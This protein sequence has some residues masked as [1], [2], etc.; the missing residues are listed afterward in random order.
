MSELKKYSSDIALKLN[1]FV[2]DLTGKDASADNL[3]PLTI[4]AIDS[5]LNNDVD[6][7][8][9]RIMFLFNQLGADKDDAVTINFLAACIQVS[10]ERNTEK[11]TPKDT[12]IKVLSDLDNQQLQ[13][14]QRIHESL[15]K[16]DCKLSK[17]EWT[18]LKKNKQ[19]QE[20]VAALSKTNQFTAQ[21]WGKIKDNEQLQKAVVERSTKD[22]YQK[23]QKDLQEFRKY[24]EEE[25][26]DTK[27]EPARNFVQ[28]SEKA[29]KA[30]LMNNET[31][32]KSS[33][34]ASRGNLDALRKHRHSGWRV[35]GT[36]LL[37]LTGVGAV[38]GLIQAGVQK[39]R[40][41]EPEFLFMGQATK[42][43]QAA[44][45]FNLPEPQPS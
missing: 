42:S 30:Y 20:A 29:S 41:K 17:D 38:A 7:N 24:T 33:I 32:F 1:K 4:L 10:Q 23:S 31:E 40:G 36:I 39:L 44:N 6:I 45:K 22:E 13:L 9:E 35:A 5:L 3:L 15:D 16:I 27:K 37:S 43:A 34:D 28:N 26:I 21:D 19:L 11:T 12:Q 2:K 14:L 25:I 18:E 8:Q